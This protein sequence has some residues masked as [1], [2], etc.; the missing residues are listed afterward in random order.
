MAKNEEKNCFLYGGQAVLEGVMMVGKSCYCTAVRDGDGE[1]Q[2]EK[3]RA[4]QSRVGKTLGKI[5]FLRGVVNLF[6]SMVRG[7]KTIMR[8]AS[9]FGEDEEPGKVSKWMAEK[10]KINVMDVITTVSVVLGVCLAV[11]IFMLLPNFLVGLLAGWL[12]AIKSTAWEYVLL[13]AFKL[14]IFLI[15]L[16]LILIMKDIRRLYQYHGAEHKTINCLEKGLPLTVENVRGCSRIHDRCGTS[17]LFIVLIINVVCISLINWAFDV[18]LIENGILK[19]L[20]K[21][22]LE[23][24]FLPLIAGTSYE[25]LRLL[26]KCRGKWSIIFKWPGILLQ[27][28][29]TT[30]E[31]DDTQIEVAICSLKS[32]MEMDA[33]ESVPEQKFAVSGVLCEMLKET[34]ALFDQNGVDESDAEWI[35]SLATGKKRSQLKGD[36]TLITL[37]QAKR[38]KNMVDQRLLGKPLW[39]VVGDTEFYGLKI[40]VDERV[41]IPRPETEILVEKA[42]KKIKLFDR[43]LDMCTGSGCI[44]VALK[45][46]APDAQVVAVDV[47]QGALEVAQ[48]NAQ[49]N[50]VQ[51]EF[52][53]SDLFEN[54]VGKFDLIACNPPYIIS[55]EIATLQTE[56]KNFEPHLA[57]DGGVDGLDFYKKI[58]TALPQFIKEGGYVIFECG[59]GQAQQIAGLF[60]T[61]KR[62]EIIRD[63]ANIERFVALT[64]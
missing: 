27:K 6:S 57:L 35:Y 40:N 13:G 30:R 47:S 64:F 58:A 42:L 16:A 63:Y 15:Y 32:A 23:V 8:S 46:H 11:A 59:E 56:V 41:L 61:A 9:V 1:I 18:H 10:L 37:A 24:L 3:E 29:F 45:K 17:F 49:E 31:P 20:A 5:P 28:A 39:Y 50:G 51:I 52:I 36:N 60:S 4:K 55:D 2:V 7:T 44:A 25:V 53:Q 48:K 22:G 26:A 38:I 43:V 54:V 19:F 14:G 21:V 62:C 12:P 34:V 33:D